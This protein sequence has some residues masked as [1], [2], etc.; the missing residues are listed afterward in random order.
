[1]A[2]F[3]S[4]LVL[5]PTCVAAAVALLSAGACSSNDDAATT[6]SRDSVDEQGNL[7]TCDGSREGRVYFVAKDSALFACT[8]GEWHAVSGGAAGATG[9]AGAT[10]SNGTNGATGPTGATGPIGGSPL[11]GGVA[12]AGLDATTPLL[13]TVKINEVESNGGSPGDWIEI[14]N[15][16][17]TTVDLA[18]FTVRDNDD[19]HNYLLAS[20]T[21]L[22]PGAYLVIEEAALGFGL[23]GAD[24]ARLFDRSLRLV[25]GY[26][27]LTHATTTYGRCPNG[28]GAFATSASST[29]GAANDCG[30]ALDGGTS[31]DGGSS[32]DGG[33]ANA[34]WPG[35]NDV[36]TVDVASTFGT[37]M[38]GLFY[39]PGV[40]A[41]TSLLWAIQNGPSK[42]YRLQASGA[43]YIS[44]PTLG[45]DTGKTLTYATGTGAPDSEGVTRAELTSAAMY[46]SSERDNNANTVSRLSIL[47]YDTDA[48]GATLTATHDWNVT[49]DIPAVGANLGLE[50]IT[51]LPD[52]YL[53]ANGFYDE[54]AAATYSPLSY[55]N[56]GTG[57]FLV[58]V[59][60]TGSL[61]AYALNHAD[62]TF[63]RV[64]TIASGQVAVMDL[65]FDRATGYLW[66]DC[67]NT[68]GNKITV[69]DIVTTPLAANMG[70]FAVRRV[71]DRP[72][73]LP[74][75]NNEGITFAPET[76]C[77][78]G[79]KSF[80][81]SDDDQTDGHA[82]RRDAIPCGRFLP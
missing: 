63:T 30:V 35:A 5:F 20:G 33:V 7:P 70:R 47:R 37:N 81:W 25:D 23:G 64:A 48:A 26:D 29:K 74:N 21:T 67:D 50:A 51:W 62:S 32:T 42:L 1:M 15:N 17:T 72:S 82:L 11:D 19:T 8:A 12:D 9:P 65:S 45:W 52:T 80:F 41:A 75:I 57:L 46:V 6:P 71:F 55:P 40:T 61:Y 49:A 31:S 44:T 66:A 77:V 22:A 60:A 68:C 59:E 3:T 4:R 58:G 14:I 39:E 27:W 54:H 2:P 18:G 53:V 10:G 24:S 78:A 43:N 16:G 56:H 69:L 79:K 38:S 76:E 36:V 13:T 73:S 28:T 34:S